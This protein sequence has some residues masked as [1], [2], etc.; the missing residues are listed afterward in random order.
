MSTIAATFRRTIHS[1]AFVA[2]VEHHPELAIELEPLAE[3]IVGDA[4]V[5]F[6]G[7]LRK[8]EPVDALECSVRF[9]HDA[10]DRDW[11][12]TPRGRRTNVEDFLANEYYATTPFDVGL[13]HG[14]YFRVRPERPSRHVIGDREARLDDAV[15]RDDAV[16]EIDVSPSRSGTWSPIVRVILLHAARADQVAPAR[17]HRTGLARSLAALSDWARPRTVP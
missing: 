11:L 4:V 3:R 7:A 9:R 12:F 2:R 1:R 15:A 17:P 10:G 6:S 14:L 16:L 5:R 8:H 13:V